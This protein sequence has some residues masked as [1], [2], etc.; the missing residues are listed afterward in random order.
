MKNTHGPFL[1][2]FISFISCAT[3]AFSYD[4]NQIDKAVSEKGQS[5]FTYALSSIIEEE[6]G[7]VVYSPNGIHFAIAQT[8]LSAG[9][10]IKIFET[11]TG[12]LVYTIPSHG[13]Q[14]E[15]CYSPNSQYIVSAGWDSAIQV[16][17]ANTGRL[18]K[19]LSLWDGVDNAHT[20]SVRTV[21]YSPDGRLI[22]S[23]SNDHMI[24]IW[25]TVNWKVLFTLKKHGS[26]VNQVNFSPDGKYLVSAG[27]DYTIGIWDMSN[28]KLLRTMEAEYPVNTAIYSF[29]GK[30]VA[31]GYDDSDN[32]IRIWDA[33][34]GELIRTIDSGRTWQVVY[35][36]NG[37]HLLAATTDSR[38]GKGGI[39]LYDTQNWDFITLTDENTQNA[40]FSPDGKYIISGGPTTKLY[41]MK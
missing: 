35:S 19:S 24:K 33:M 30:Y 18:Y 8:S 10:F 37:K 39:K 29:D 1:F 26:P 13:Y 38:S 17:D 41:Q 7:S 6:S 21:A 36:P 31:A 25:D 2:L 5:H 27:S 34:T 40:A 16:W 15:L 3:V 9:R 14:A 32:K 22:A 28:G 12:N 11:A 23:G 20:D 4:F